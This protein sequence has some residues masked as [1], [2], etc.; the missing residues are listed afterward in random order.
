MCLSLDTDRPALPCNAGKSDELSQAIARIREMEALY[1]RLSDAL[2]Q[3]PAGGAAD[4]GLHE[5]IRRLSVYQSGGGWLHDYELDEQGLLPADLK[6]GV[7]SQDGLY[8]L[9]SCPALEALAGDASGVPE[10]SDGSEA[11]P[12][13]P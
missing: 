1:D 5:A 4:D 9:L 10:A 11:D 6:R 13:L 12:W 2:R 7:L 3:P 8:D